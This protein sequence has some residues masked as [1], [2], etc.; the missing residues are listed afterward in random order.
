MA[1]PLRVPVALSVICFNVSA[2]SLL[3]RGAPVYRMMQIS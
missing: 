2:K 1:V 3:G